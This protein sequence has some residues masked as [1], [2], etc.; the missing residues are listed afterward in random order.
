MHN[1]EPFQLAQLP[2]GARVVVAMSGGVDSSVTAAMLKAAGYDVIG[3]TLQ[4]YDH[5][6]HVA[7]PGA[8][9]A[10]RDIRDAR[11]VADV[12]GIPHYVLDFETRFRDCVIRPFAA[13]YMAGETPVPC[14]ACNETVKFT[15]LL[16]RA[17]EMGA[18]AL[19]TGHYVQSR[20]TPDGWALY[21]PR[22]TQRDQSY[23]L[24][25]LTQDQ[26]AFLRFPLGALTK[27]E[28]RALAEKLSLPIAHKPDSQDICFVPE[29][30]YE[31]VVSRYHSG[32]AAAGDIIH[33]DGTRL[34]RHEGIHHFTIGQRRGLGIA[35][36]TPL[37]VLHIDPEKRA[38]IVGPKSHLRVH[39]IGLRNVNWLG[40]TPLAS[41][42]S[43][44]LAMHV[45]VRSTQPPMP[46]RLRRQADG[47]WVEILDGE[48]GVSPG[49]ACVFYA[50]GDPT[51]RVLGGGWIDKTDAMARIQREDKQETLGAH[52]NP[53]R[54]EAT[55][56]ETGDMTTSPMAAE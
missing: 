21:R 46:A 28:I 51:A 55:M 22:D 2:P 12:I 15:D 26:L 7:R 9:C 14:I 16:A 18:A 17:K 33:V 31:A 29:G 20:P 49:Q 23:F 25:T 11:R 44:G 19:V 8:C 54:N 27:P 1:A 24:F 43:Q 42:P 5:G 56:G 13:S 36:G 52:S 40:D 35:T 6:A 41:L 32:V 30:G 50:G 39:H 53:G 3:V 37:Y 45:R 38:I 10:G 48:D 34:G 47:F 4:L